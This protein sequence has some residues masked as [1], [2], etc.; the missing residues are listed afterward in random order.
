MYDGPAVNTITG[1]W[2]LIGADVSVLADG[3][4][5]T[6][7]T[8]SAT[9]TITFPLGTTVEKVHIGLGYNAE[10]QTVPLAM[11]GL[12]AFATAGMKN[13]SSTY[14]RVDRTQGLEAG[15]SFDKLRPFPP[16]S[17]EVWGSPPSLKST[18]I[19]IP[20]TPHWTINGQVCVRQAQPLPATIL[21]IVTEYETE[22]HQQ[23]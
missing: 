14:L 19:E 9:G 5:F 10:L 20:M 15:P 6:G 4:V 16:R 21:G 13:A 23:G 18:V 3:S 11:E 1:L 7:F 22:Y 12:P 8:V 17:T 2:H